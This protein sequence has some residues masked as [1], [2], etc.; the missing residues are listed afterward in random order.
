MDNHSINL[1]ELI[2][3]P[4]EI[5]LSLMNISADYDSTQPEDHECYHSSTLELVSPG[6]QLFLVILYSVT[7]LLSLLGNVTVIA[8]QVVGQQSAASVRR[9]LISLAIADIISGVLCVPF[10]F[11][12]FTLRQW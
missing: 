12:N 7:A 4:E 6:T 10:S 2:E 8:V 1:A 5:E 3:S 11:T 9:H